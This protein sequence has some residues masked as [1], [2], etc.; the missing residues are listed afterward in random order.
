MSYFPT[1]KICFLFLL[2]FLILPYGLR[3]SSL[4]QS[5]QQIQATYEKATDVSSEFT[6]KIQ[7]QSIGREIEKAGKTFFKK[8]GKFK[9][10]YDGEE[11]RD[12]ISNGKK[13][14]VYDKGDT[15]VNVYGVSAKTIPE[16]ALSFLGGLG[17]LRAQFRVSAVTQ[18]EQARLN[19]KDDLDWLLLIPKNEQSKLDELILGF[20]KK[21]H[22]VSEAFLKNESGNTSHYFFKNV[23]TNSGIA[24][25][26][27]EFKSVKGVKEIKH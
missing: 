22:L 6:Q 3:A 27:F 4:E 13:L 16:E 24:E 17:N 26:V 21:S 11:G 5:I 1:K 18:E 8:P 2:F 9:V 25:E 10:S 12:Y 7:V 20:D 14:W 23:K 19:V 15:Q